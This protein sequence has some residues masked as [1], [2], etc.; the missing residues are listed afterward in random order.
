MRIGAP[1]GWGR[2][3]WAQLLQQL[4]LIGEEAREPVDDQACPP[5]RQARARQAGP[6]HKAGYAHW[7]A[8]VWPGDRPRYSR[9][10]QL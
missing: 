6:Q 8:I 5:C 1:S 2:E 7:S 10:L 3:L 4:D 9:Q